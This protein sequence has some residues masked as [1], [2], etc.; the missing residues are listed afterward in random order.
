MAAAPQLFDPAR[1]TLVLRRA[2]RAGAQ[3][4]L[5]DRLAEDLQDRLGAVLRRFGAALDIGTPHG[6]FG[7]AV[8]ASGRAESLLYA[9]EPPP[10]EASARIALG[11]PDARLA[12]SS[13]DLVVSAALF[14][15]VDD[16]PGLLIQLR[17]ALRPDGLLLAAFPGGETLHE[18]R[19]CLLTAESELAGQAVLRVMPAIDVR[20]AGQ[21][22]QRAGF[23]LPVVD[24]ERLTLTY[25]DPLALIRDLRAMGA[26]GALMK[27]PGIPPLTRAVML[28]AAT[29][30]AERYARPDGRIGATIEIVWMSGWTPHESQQQPLKPG[31]AK[32]RLADAL[33]AMARQRGER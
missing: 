29:L 21:L 4:F 6:A 23:A 15:R 24:S 31:S 13:F 20:S 25:A 2:E 17:R 5:L 7:R 32:A 8:L 19:D 14:H 3:T 28:R 27:R 12:P 26:S 9:C 11:L 18:L 1:A 16:L 10:I 33:A 30:Y 22:L